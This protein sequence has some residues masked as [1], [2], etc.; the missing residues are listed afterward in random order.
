[1][2]QVHTLFSSS[3]F[4]IYFF[5]VA[6]EYVFTTLGARGENGPSS[7]SGYSGTTL[8]DNVI[9]Q[10]G[11]QIWTVPVTG[12][13]IIEARGG[14]GANGTDGNPNIY[15]IPWRLGGLGATITGTFQLVQGIQLKILVGQEGG[16]SDD[17]NDMPGGGGGGSFV[18]LLDNT[19]LIV[20]GGGGG[21]GTARNNFTDG[22][23]GQ[24]TE[25]GTQCGGTGGT[26]GYVC[27][28]DTGIIDPFIVAGGGAGISGDGIGC[29]VLDTNP[30]SFINGG[31]GGTWL[32]T[33]GGFGGGS[34][35]M[36][37]SGGGGGY[38]GGGVVGTNTKG[39]AG[40]GGSYNIGTNQ[41]NVAGVNKGDGKV[42]IALIT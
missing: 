41:Q 9:L 3:F 17:F 11:I 24:A 42:I 40:G 25:N 12:S 35:A 29:I 31:A 7:T 6:T 23:P 10:N 39:T 8:E 34:C 5:I 37:L 16:R 36:A 4:F 18:T 19:P 15:P 20:A 13:Y 32:S 28:A 14:S 33:Y 2:I 30:L 1:M 22:D 27:N 26:G 38:S 21:G